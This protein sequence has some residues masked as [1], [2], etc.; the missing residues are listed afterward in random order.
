MKTHHTLF[1]AYAL[2]ALVSCGGSRLITPEEAYVLLAPNDWG[3]VHRFQIGMVEFENDNPADAYKDLVDAGLVAV[4][5]RGKRTLHIALTKAGMEHA[6]S[7]PFE[8]SGRTYVLVRLCDRVFLRVHNVEWGRIRDDQDLEATVQFY[9][10]HKRLTPFGSNYRK[11]SGGCSPEVQLR[12]IRL[13]KTVDPDP[14]APWRIEGN[15]D[16]MPGRM[17]P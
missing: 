4:K 14:D 7:E 9:V 12:S 16:E 13:V 2:V 5:P 11:A 3:V 1:V 15:P 8:D 17:D 6:R 10:T